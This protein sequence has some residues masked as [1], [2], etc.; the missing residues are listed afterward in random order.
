MKCWL[1]PDRDCDEKCAAFLKLEIFDTQAIAGH[2]VPLWSDSKG[3]I[4]TYC[5]IIHSLW[6]LGEGLRNLTNVSGRKGEERALR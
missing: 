3:E 2:G 1:Y 6:E 4:R 5:A